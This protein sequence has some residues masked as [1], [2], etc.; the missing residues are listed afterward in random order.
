MG[1]GALG[2]TLSDFD[3]DH[4]LDPASGILRGGHIR[5]TSGGEAPISSFGRIPPGEV[6]SN[7]GSEWKKA[8]LQWHD[9]VATITC[10]AEHL[11]YRHNFVD[12][13]PTYTDKF[14]DPL[15]R[16][17][18]DWTDHERRQAAMASKVQQ[19][20]AKAMGGRVGGSVRGVGA[21]YY[22]TDYQSTHVQGGAIMGTSP[23]KQRGEPVVP[24][25]AYA[26]PVGG[27]RLGVSAECVGQS[28][29]DGDGDGVPRGGRA[30]RPL[31]EAAR[32]A[33]MK[34]REFITLPAKAWAAFSCTRWR[35]SRCACR[36]SRARCAFRFAS[37]RPQRRAWWSPPANGSFP[38]TRAARAPPKPAW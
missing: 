11:A 9:R 8:A 13:D 18:L 12:L 32:G 27:R 24:A 38:A 7:W 4:G 3:G 21:H 29:A 34:R 14:G 20:L 23:G 5:M 33:G 1:A 17:T 25:L 2:V 10:E 31:P 22:V 30:D 28:H 37:S 36:R 35:A 15:L 26:E 6:K 16:L 19:S